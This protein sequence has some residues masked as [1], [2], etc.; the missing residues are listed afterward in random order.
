VR[1]AAPTRYAFYLAGGYAVV[2]CAY[3]VL[4]TQLAASGATSIEALEAAELRKG[5]A[6]VVVTSL[7]FLGF[8]YALFRRL[9][10]ASEALLQRRQ[11][12]VLAQRQATAGLFTASIAHDFNNLLSVIQGSFE[13][14]AEGL[15]DEALR[16]MLDDGREATRRGALL[17]QRLAAASRVSS[18]AVRAPVDLAEAARTVIRLLGKHPALASTDLR[19]GA[20]DAPPVEA[21][22]GLVDQIL[23]NLVLNGA[24]AAGP[25]GRVEIRVIPR[26]SGVVLEV[27]DSGPGVAPE[28]RQ[29]IF[30]AFETQAGGLGLGL[31]SAK[32]C[33]AAQGGSVQITDSDLGGACLAVHFAHEAAPPELPSLLTTVERAETSG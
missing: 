13:E 25:G 5:L 18:Q 10:A 14:V 30:D 33:A 28:D 4:S 22:V 3:I 1:A 26:P 17:A 32:L 11:E 2:G 24:R 20:G 23:T 8:S 9:E 6:Y 7:L 27:H 19:L 12:L 21:D 31:L 15:R 29:R 16:E